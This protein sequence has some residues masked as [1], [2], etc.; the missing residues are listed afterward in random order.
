MYK[1]LFLWRV[2][3][4]NTCNTQRKPL[5]LVCRLVVTGA[6]IRVQ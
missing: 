6:D 4:G 1:Q 2:F 5:Q 3:M